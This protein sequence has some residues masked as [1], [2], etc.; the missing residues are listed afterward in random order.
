MEK[1]VT[2]YPARAKGVNIGATDTRM[3]DLDVNIGF[4]PGLRLKLLPYHLA[5]GGLAVCAN[6][7]LKLVVRHGEV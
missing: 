3:S 4:F 1:E 7:A 6:P 2:T 5:V